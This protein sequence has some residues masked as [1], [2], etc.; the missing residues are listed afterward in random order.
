MS[1]TR[2]YPRE[3]ALV[4]GPI[5]PDRVERV[6][7]GM[8]KEGVASQQLVQLGF[9]P[10][11]LPTGLT[12]ALLSGQLPERAPGQ[13]GA[14]AGG[15]WVREQW[16]VHAPVPLGTSLSIS[17]SSLRRFVKRGREYSVTSSETRDASGRLLVANLTTGLLRYRADPDRSDE[18]EG[19]QDSEL[20][21]P[22]P[23]AAGA[24]SNPSLEAL[25]A[26][27]VGDTLQ[28]QA[29]DMSLARLQARDGPEP[30]NPIHSDPEAARRAG[31]DV[32]IAGGAHVV[33]FLQEALL[34]AWGVEALYHGALLDARWI[35]PVRAG[36]QIVP[37]AQVVTA[38]PGR[39]ELDFEVRCADTAACVG[40]IAIPL[41]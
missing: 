22:S 6:L 33:A 19:V 8:G 21:T 2:S 3:L 29:I 1:R 20:P 7:A 36:S 39:V 9:A 28:G 41:A 30:A 15:V 5:P 34:Q 32:P 40:H 10:P 23:D 38:E 16:T 27:R 35:S 26:L 12:L 37:R 18:E 24:G 13:P 25:R 14:V 4:E 31:L 17:G 11:E